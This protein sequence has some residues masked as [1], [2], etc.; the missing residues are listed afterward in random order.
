MYF[1]ATKKRQVR[2]GITWRRFALQPTL[3]GHSVT[4]LTTYGGPLVK[5]IS[6]RAMLVAY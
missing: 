3:E 1:L 2:V 5:G 4:H 6:M